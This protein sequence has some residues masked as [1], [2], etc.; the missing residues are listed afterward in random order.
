[1]KNFIK[2]ILIK[3]NG[4]E[5]YNLSRSPRPSKYIARK[6]NRDWCGTYNNDFENN[7]QQKNGDN[8]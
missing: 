5:R 7:K 6:I 8:K 1:M 4:S 2:K 3:L